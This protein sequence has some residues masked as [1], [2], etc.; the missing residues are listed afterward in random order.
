MITSKVEEKFPGNAG[1]SF[2]VINCDS[3]LVIKVYDFN[4][5]NLKSYS[6]LLEELDLVKI[7]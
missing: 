3:T 7:K 6:T 4:S 2:S 5:R 1:N